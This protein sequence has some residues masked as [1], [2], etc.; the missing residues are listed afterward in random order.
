MPDLD[1]GPSSIRDDSICESSPPPNKS[2]GDIGE[3]TWTPEQ[4]WE[5]AAAFLGDHEAT[6]S[7]TMIEDRGLVLIPAAEIERR[8]RLISAHQQQIIDG[9]AMLAAKDAEIERL[10]LGYR[11]IMEGLI[12][13]RV[14]G[15]DVVW[16]DNIETLFD[17]CDVMINGNEP[18]QFH[19]LK[20]LEDRAL[21]AESAAAAAMERER[22]SFQKYIDANEAHIEAVKLL[23][24]VH[25]LGQTAGWRRMP[26]GMLFSATELATDIASAIR[27]AGAERNSTHKGRSRMNED[28]RTELEKEIIKSALAHD[29]RYYLQRRYGRG[30][31]PHYDACASL[32]GRKEATWLVSTGPGIQLQR[33]YSV[34]ELM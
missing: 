22:D 23:S 10:R 29:G 2:S 6:T 31:N 5:F 17:F 24:R 20:S 18:R 33:E 26:T 19:E 11:A 21:T 25:K 7:R 32:V 9:S 3:R 13:G 16:Y 4:F 27:A 8:D 15:D 1:T 28:A 12:A 30:P 14:G 34:S